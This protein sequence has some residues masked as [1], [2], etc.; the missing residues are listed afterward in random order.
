MSCGVVGQPGLVVQRLPLVHEGQVHPAESQRSEV[1]SK[2]LPQE[3]SRGWVGPPGRPPG[4]QEEGSVLRPVQV[5]TR[6]GSVLF[7]GRLPRGDSSA[8]SGVHPSTTTLRVRGGNLRF[9]VKARSG[10]PLIRSPGSK[11]RY[12]RRE[13]GSRWPT[14]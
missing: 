1:Q 9:M 7:L 11:P 10:S 12:S 6:R 3:R 2:H 4:P 5:P 13:P 8:A 14:R